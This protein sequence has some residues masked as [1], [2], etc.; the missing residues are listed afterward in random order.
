[1]NINDAIAPGARGRP[2]RCGMAGKT[3][4]HHHM[5]HVAAKPENQPEAG[6]FGI[7][8]AGG[9]GKYPWMP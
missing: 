8:I 3:G 4:G 9:G 1:M 5:A 2:T 7:T 6:D